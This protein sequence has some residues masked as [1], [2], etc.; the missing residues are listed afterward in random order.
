MCP[1]RPQA[2]MLRN[3]PVPLLHALNP[4]TDRQ[5]LKA[6]FISRNRSRFRCAERIRK[7]GNGRIGTLYLVDVGRIEG[8]REGSQG[9]EGRVRG[10]NAMRM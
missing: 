9:H 8:G 10:S 2:R 1:P 7:G 5:H 4:G 3:C 6:G